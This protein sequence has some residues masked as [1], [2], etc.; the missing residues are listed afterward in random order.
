MIRLQEVYKRYKRGGKEFLAV[1][2]CSFSLDKGSRTLVTGANGSGKSTLLALMGS[3]IRPTGGRIFCNNEEISGLSEPFRSR[4][5]LQNFGFHFQDETLLNGLTVLENITLA[6][7]PCLSGF[8][9]NRLRVEA[10][11]E[12]LCLDVGL[13]TKVEQLSGGQR[14]KVCLARALINDPPII[15]ADEPT[16]HLDR[17]SASEIRRMLCE[18]KERGKTVI[19]VSHDPLFIENYDFDHHLKLEQGRVEVSSGEI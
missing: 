10:L 15:F 3:L 16:N 9:E 11:L 6:S 12:R 1:E 18:L 7:L 17:R 2:E 19:I 14:Q 5:R 13:G 4:F 8:K